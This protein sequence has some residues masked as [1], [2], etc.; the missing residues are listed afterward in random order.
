MRFKLII[1][2]LTCFDHELY[3]STSIKL[4]LQKEGE[5]G[6]ASQNRWLNE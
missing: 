6:K 5:G 1:S 3:K 2:R 4:V